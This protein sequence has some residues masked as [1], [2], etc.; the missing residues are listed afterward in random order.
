MS[1]KKQHRPIVPSSQPRGI[2]ISSISKK[3]PLI[4]AV[5]CAASKDG[6]SFSIHG[7]DMDP[8]CLGRYFV[9]YFW[10][11][12]ES[13]ELTRQNILDYCR[14]HN[15]NVIIPTRDGELEFFAK[16]SSWLAQQN[17]H[18]MISPTS[19]IQLSLDKKR[20]ADWLSEHCFPAIPTALKI[21]S[22]EAPKYVVKERFG[23]GSKSLGIKLSRKD[24]LEHASSLKNAIFQP[25]IEGQ[26]FS[27]DVYRERSTKIKGV[28]ARTRDLV[29][30]GE[31][32]VTTTVRKP[33][34]ELM[35]SQI[36]D[37]LD[38]YG[39]AVFQIIESADGSLHVIECNPRFGGAS[40]ASIAAGLDS[41]HWFLC[42]AKN[43]SLAKH[44]F[45]RIA[46]EI[47]QIRYPNDKTIKVM[48][49]PDKVI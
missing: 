32:Q 39:H 13:A 9:D 48:N 1:P 3:I 24:A 14:H 36:A 8:R 10:Q 43:E 4:E 7:C 21:D 6:H 20:F 40:T 16:H 41:F 37:A 47:R 38:I 34:M 2:L 26:E 33:K 29:I 30:N 25:F 17:I 15:I 19:S 18:I 22:L 23:A 45:Q 27:V 44:P 31:S 46:G 5:R 28:V 35:C 12:P 42:E 49:T 11:T